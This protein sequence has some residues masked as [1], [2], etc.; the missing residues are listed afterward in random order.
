MRVVLPTLAVVLASAALLTHVALNPNEESWLTLS[1]R[2]SF[3]L[4]EQ[5]CG[6][7]WH[8]ALWRD[9]RGDWWWGPCV[10]NR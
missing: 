7:G 8:Q 10:P 3:W 1:A 5:A 9:R 4:T 2:L 6:E